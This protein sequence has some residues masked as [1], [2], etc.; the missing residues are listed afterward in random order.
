MSEEASLPAEGKA[1]SK[2]HSALLQRIRVEAASKGDDKLANTFSKLTD[3]KLAQKIFAN[4]R[5]GEDSRGLRLTKFGLE[6][7]KK[8]F[9]F[10]A[11]PLPDGKIVKPRTLV[12]LDRRATMPYYVSN[13]GYVVFERDLGFK[14]KLAEGN[15]D[16][17]REIEG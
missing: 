8:Y 2:L 11:V 17:V 13:E 7:M 9:W 3:D 15:M 5:G 14:L 12:Y 6:V 1:V 4:L 16:V 10:L